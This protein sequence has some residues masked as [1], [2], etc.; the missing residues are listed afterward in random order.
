[1]KKFLLAAAAVCSI[2]GFA[3]S[4]SADVF[5]WS[6]SGGAG[7]SGS[8]T[9]TASFVSGVTYQLTGITGTANGQT[10]TGLSSYDGPDQLIFPTSPVVI[11][12]L[13]FAFSVA[14][15]NSYNLYE[16]FG[17][18]TPGPPYG[19]GAEYCLL[20][21]GTVGPGDQD[22]ALTSF[23]ITPASAAPEPAIWAMM[24]AGFFGVGFVMRGSRRKD[25]VAA[26]AATV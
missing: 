17:N 10:I 3:G 14:G 2:V 21:P 26:V 13:G 6:Y 22:V 7:V 15:G 5:D 19:C 24:L 12:T 18:Y 16:D 11:D 1:M 9:F 23:T 4:A 25:A 8:G 20:G